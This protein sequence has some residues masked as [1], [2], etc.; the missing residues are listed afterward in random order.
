VHNYVICNRHQLQ[1]AEAL[2][3]AC[4]MRINLSLSHISH[5]SSPPPQKNAKMQTTVIMT[6]YCLNTQSTPVKNWARRGEVIKGFFR[7]GFTVHM[8]LRM[9]TSIFR[10]VRRHSSSLQQCYLHHLNSPYH[11]DKK[12]VLQK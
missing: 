12:Q 4:I 5:S 7:T 3:V 8:C 11:K 10:L 6:H 9:A 1:W 2:L